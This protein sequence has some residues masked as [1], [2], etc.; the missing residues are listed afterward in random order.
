[1]QALLHVSLGQAADLIAGR[2]SSGDVTRLEGTPKD[3][4]IITKSG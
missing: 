1:M 2:S 4:A 3:L